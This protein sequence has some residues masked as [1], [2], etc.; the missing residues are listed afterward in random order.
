MLRFECRPASKVHRFDV[1]GSIQPWCETTKEPSM[2]ATQIRN[3]EDEE[4]TWSQ[5]SNMSVHD[6]DAVVEVLDEAQR[7]DDV[8]LCRGE[9]VTED[10]GLDHGT[11]DAEQSKV[12][13]CC[14]TPDGGIVDRSDSV[15]FLL[16]DVREVLAG[17]ASKLGGVQR[18]I[19]RQVCVQ[20]VQDRVR[21][22]GSR[23][24]LCLSR[25]R[26]VRPV[27]VPEVLV[28]PALDGR[29]RRSPICA[30]CD[31]GSK[32]W[33]RA[34]HSPPPPVRGTAG[35]PGGFGVVGGA[36]EYPPPPPEL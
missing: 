24:A 14:R 29:H 27:P 9:I 17:G 25:Q 13:P 35:P 10:V 34:G 8:E 30:L 5:E 28:C 36:G 6:R 22:H 21:V 26:H 4:A 16:V 7:E 18:G 32:K 23:R 19:R 2:E 1:V 31:S 3:T 11:V 20:H 15:A 33:H 12:L